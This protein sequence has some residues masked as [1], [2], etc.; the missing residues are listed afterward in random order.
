MDMM[1]RIIAEADDK[2]F[3]SFGDVARGL[4]NMQCQYAS[5]YIDG[6]GGRPVLADGLRIVGD[7]GNYHSLKIHK[8]DI[9]VFVDRVRGARS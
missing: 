3:V 1:D 6:V 4:L 5:Y 8:D 9:Q 2:G 7:S